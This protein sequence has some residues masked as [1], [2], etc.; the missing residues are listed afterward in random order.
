[1]DY[2]Q[3]PILNNPDENDQDS[4]IF[5]PFERSNIQY[6]TRCVWFLESSVI[7][8]VFMQSVKASSKPLPHPF[9]FLFMKAD[10]YVP[11]EKQG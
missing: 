5:Q 7:S 6:L 10:L 9:S 4:F 3:L 1:M 8:R 2:I 11:L